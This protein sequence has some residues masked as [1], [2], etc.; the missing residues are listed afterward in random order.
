MPSYLARVL[1]GRVS[2][3]KIDVRGAQKV[4]KW[5]FGNV[6]I[7]GLF[8]KFIEFS[9]YERRFGA[10]GIAGGEPA[11]ARISPVAHSAAFLVGRRL[12]TCRLL[13]LKSSTI[14]LSYSYYTS[15]PLPRANSF[16]GTKN[17]AHYRQPSSADS[18]VVDSRRHSDDW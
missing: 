17:F 4:S 15:S 2:R 1:T 3:A 8:Y 16:T 5:K 10:P 12:M 13:I 9:W 18:S 11:D 7:F 14:L 6:V